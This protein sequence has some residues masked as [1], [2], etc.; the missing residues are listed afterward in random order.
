VPTSGAAF[1][2]YVVALGGFA[3]TGIAFL[4]PLVRRGWL[5]LRPLPARA[6]R[7][8]QF[9]GVNYLGQLAVQAPFFAVPFVV[10]VQVSA[11]ENARFYLSWGVMSVVYISVQMIGQA[12]L[13]EGGRGGADHRRQ[14]AVSL[15]AGLAVATTATVLS[16]A[17]G[18]LLASLYGPA[19]GPVATLLPLLVGGTIPFAVTMTLLTMARIRERSNSTIAVAVAFAVAVLVPTVLL[20]ASDGVLGAAWGW[21]IGNTIAAAL[22]ALASRL[23]GPEGR[24]R[25]RSEAETT[26]VT[27]IPGWQ[28]G[29]H[30]E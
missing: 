27:P 23:P 28:R 13:V 24:E 12:L 20:T 19:Y 9:A 17:L 14:A 18:P 10:L 3:L 30:G 1:Y 7:A 26:L 4:A 16:L 22:A 11:V 15:G 6:R 21:T 5:R 29:G 8:A 2:V 25:A